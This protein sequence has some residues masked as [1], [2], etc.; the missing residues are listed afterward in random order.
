MELV[1]GKVFKG[2]ER[3]KGD[4]GWIE[5]GMGRK[6]YTKYRDV[7]MSALVDIF[8]HFFNSYYGQKNGEREHGC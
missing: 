2:N 3:S 7:L 8:T 5:V 1:E 4:N 6:Q